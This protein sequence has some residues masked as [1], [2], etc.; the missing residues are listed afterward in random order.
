[1]FLLYP[2]AAAIH[3][4]MATSAGL[5]EVVGYGLSN[6]GYVLGAAGVMAGRFGI[7]G[8]RMR[9][10]VFAAAVLSYGFGTILVN[11]GG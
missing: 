1:V 9:W 11:V 2:L 7:L 4:A 8:L 5:S 6:L 10:Q 3:T